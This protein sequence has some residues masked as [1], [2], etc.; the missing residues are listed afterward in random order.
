MNPNPKPILTTLPGDIPGLTPP[1]WHAVQQHDY[2]P[3]PASQTAR[4][5]VDTARMAPEQIA[6]EVL[7]V[8]R[9]RL[10]E[11]SGE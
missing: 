1:S 11:K 7:A 6:T 2:Q 8:L 4:C 10:F 3:W 9:Q 5:V